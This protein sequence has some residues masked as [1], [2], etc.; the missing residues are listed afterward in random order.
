MPDLLGL[1][2]P[3][4]L[5]APVIARLLLPADNTAPLN[6]VG[7]R[8]LPGQP[9]RYI[10]IVCT[11]GDIPT[12]KDDPRCSQYA[13]AHPPL[14]AYVGLIEAQPG[15]NPHLLAR[16]ASVDGMVDWR[17]T[18][19]PTAP[20][21]LDD[22]HGD[23]IPASSWNRFDLAPYRIALGRTAFGLRGGWSDGFSG[24]MASYDA[25]FLFAVRHG[26]LREVL[27]V[28]MSSYQDLAGDWHKDGTRDHEI[29]QGANILL[30]GTH[31]TDGHFDL[32]LKSRDGR[33]HRLYR[34][35]AAAGAYRPVGK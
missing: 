2:L 19:L 24:G 11:G 5:A 29:S 18:D 28:P 4:G 6:A 32:L 15:R 26:A 17:H 35:S 12:G 31:R 16:P 34:W 9:D 7:A 1:H 8:P 14:H 22:A 33:H 23:R 21:A 27:A 20:E 13:G 3:P 10:A 25:L 30:V